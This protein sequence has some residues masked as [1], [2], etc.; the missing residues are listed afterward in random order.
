MP[1]EIH[2]E[3]REDE[4]CECDTQEIVMRFPGAEKWENWNSSAKQCFKLLQATTSTVSLAPGHFGYIWT[5][6]VNDYSELTLMYKADILPALSGLAHE[7]LQHNP[8]KYLAGLWE[9]DIAFQLG[10]RR[11]PYIYVENS[12]PDEEPTSTQRVMSLG[13]SFSWISSAGPVDFQI[14]SKSFLRFIV[15]ICALESSDIKHATEDPCGQ[16]LTGCSIRLKGRFANIS[17]FRS[18][19]DRPL[20]FLDY[21]SAYAWASETSED[22][23]ILFGLYEHPDLLDDTG[24]PESV[25]GLLLQRKEHTTEY[26][27]VGVVEFVTVSQ[28][29]EVAR[30]G[31]FTIV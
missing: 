22:T 24:A 2:F 23:T 14:Y 17:E 27:R 6:I 13:P 29:Y 8:G 10:W 25:V 31:T 3:C 4:A 21:S 9:R 16:V 26:V 18:K 15:P 1:E 11:A 30:E 5:R 19:D 7:A 20:I 28:F 12:K